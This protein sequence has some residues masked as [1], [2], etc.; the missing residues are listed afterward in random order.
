VRSAKVTKFSRYNESSDS[1]E[2]DTSD[3]DSSSTN[4]DANNVLE[5]AD[6]V[7]RPMSPIDDTDAPTDAAVDPDVTLSP[8]ESPDNIDSGEMSNIST[9]HSSQRNLS[10]TEGPVA[11]TDQADLPSK[12]QVDLPAKGGIITEHPKSPSQDSD[13]S[14]LSSDD[15]PPMSPIRSPLRLESGGDFRRGKDVTDFQRREPLNTRRPA[16][17]LPRKYDSSP[18]YSRHRSQRSPLRT[19]DNFQSHPVKNSSN[20]TR[21]SHSVSKQSSMYHHSATYSNKTSASISSRPRSQERRP[22]K[23]GSHSSFDRASLSPLS[24]PLGDREDG[25]KY[26]SQLEHS[27][28]PRSPLGGKSPGRGPSMRHD[29]PVR[30]IPRLS[31]SRSTSRSFHRQSGGNSRSRSRGRFAGSPSKSRSCSPVGDRPFQRRRSESLER[32]SKLLPASSSARHMVSV[33][34]S[35]LYDKSPARYPAVVDPYEEARR[36]RS[37]RSL[38]TEGASGS[39]YPQNLSLKSTIESHR[40]PVKMSPYRR[41]YSGSPDQA[42]RQA[43]TKSSASREFLEKPRSKSRSSSRHKSG[44][45]RSPDRHFSPSQHGMNKLNERRQD[46]ARC[47][48]GYAKVKPKDGISGR[49]PSVRDRL[50]PQPSMST[51]CISDFHKRLPDKRPS[52]HDLTV[53]QRHDRGAILLQKTKE[54]IRSRVRNRSPLSPDST[55]ADTSSKFDSRC[56]LDNLKSKLPPKSAA[57]SR[58]SVRNKYKEDS[59]QLQITYIGTSVDQSVGSAAVD[60]R[61][62]LTELDKSVQE[63]SPESSFEST[64]SPHR[65]PIKAQD[66]ESTKGKSKS[67]DAGKV[68]GHKAVTLKRPT[69]ASAAVLEAR[70]QRFK[71]M[72][73]AMEDS[74][75][76]CIRSESKGESRSKPPKQSLPELLDRTKGLGKRLKEVAEKRKIAEKSKT[77]TNEG[78]T[79]TETLDVSDITS[80]DSSISLEDISEDETPLVRDRW[81]DERSDSQPIQQRSGHASKLREQT[82]QDQTDD[83]DDNSDCEDRKPSTV[84]SSIVMPARKDTAVSEAQHPVARHGR[85]AVSDAQSTAADDEILVNAPK[86]NVISKG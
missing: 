28:Q 2:G 74:R 76:V 5:N 77:E 44:S 83:D 47:L 21:P 23:P 16:A 86:R 20:S 24:S 7:T 79:P 34:G 69:A 11:S 82:V 73:Q 71:L 29:S 63:K 53:S 72:P 13:S 8:A 46:G 9:E 64:T 43:G 30:N 27:S 41:S 38:S 4:S 49:L 42:D 22:T 14:S 45:P 31:R 65:E 1:D 26:S 81:F 19:S 6:Y 33:S 85:S 15:A 80:A 75:S 10:D 62:K 32:R 37:S 25:S 56:R 68:K 40:A 84:A 55:S 57:E 60:K 48:S 17:A 54:V 36:R 3:S 52:A 59:T 50:Y 66:E 12:K 51:D 18:S 61:K 39:R 67:S 35:Q 78:K 58:D 70:K